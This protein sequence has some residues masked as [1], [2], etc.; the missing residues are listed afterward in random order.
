ME[1]YSRI[2][3]R[4]LDEVVYAEVE[5]ARGGIGGALDVPASPVIITDI[6]HAVVPHGNLLAFHDLCELLPG[7]VVREQQSEG[8]KMARLTSGE[9]Y[10]SIAADGSNESERTKRGPE[11]GGGEGLERGIYGRAEAEGTATK[12][13]KTGGRRG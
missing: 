4:L 6:D 11:Q 2:V 10:L 9:I 13:A 12:R 1:D 8:E 3:F 7:G 5:L